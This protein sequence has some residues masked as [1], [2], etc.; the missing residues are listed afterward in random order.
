MTLGQQI[1]QCRTARGFSQ[2]ELAEMV[3]IEQSYLSKLENDKS[4]PSNEVFRS[5]LNALSISISQFLE[6]IDSDKHRQQLNQIP[7]LEAFLSQQAHL[8]LKSLRRFLYIASAL[9]ILGI[10]TFYSGFSKQL[11]S[12]KQYQY[13]SL[14]VVLPGEPLDIFS[15]WRRTIDSSA[16]NS[17][18]IREKKNIE[19]TMRSDSLFLLTTDNKS[20]NFS[21][22]VEG[23]KRLYFLDKEIAVSRQVNAWLQLFGILFFTTGVVGFALE[24]RLYKL[25]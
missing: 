5:L 14:G 17:R 6:A 11:F 7:D 12:E 13:Q 23:G 19:M 25:Q 9:I 18:S 16:P 3:G 1:K 4:I 15:S 21:V 22:D 10:T 2:P 20:Q 24:R 8:N